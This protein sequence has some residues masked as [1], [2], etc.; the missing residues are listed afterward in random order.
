MGAGSLGSALAGYPGFRRGGITIRALFDTDPRKVG[1]KRGG[2]PVLGLASLETVARREKIEIAILALP[3]E[4]AQ[5][6]AERLAACGIRG[7]MNFAP[8]RLS[9]APEVRVLDVDLGLVLEDL[10]FHLAAA[11][12]T[13]A[14]PPPPR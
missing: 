6:V 9:L 1:S 5:G 8:V 2:V 3:S 12:V 7:I 13:L 10:T 4:E 11:R 14:V